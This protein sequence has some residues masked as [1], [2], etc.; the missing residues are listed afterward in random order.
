MILENVTTKIPHK[1]VIDKLDL[2]LEVDMM[3]M[4]QTDKLDLADPESLIHWF[5]SV[6]D[7]TVFKYG[8]GGWGGQD[9]RIESKL[10][11][12]LRVVEYNAA[13]DSEREFEIIIKTTLDNTKLR[14][15]KTW[16]MQFKVLA[17]DDN[18]NYTLFQ[19][20]VEWTRLPN[21]SLNREG[22]VEG[23]KRRNLFNIIKT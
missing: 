22:F 19:H 3:H 17:L 1:I 13:G 18:Y 16:V 2:D 20:Q 9:L 5:Y 8:F 14:N 10:P 12:R 7:N 11:H 6:C 23:L 4:L 21:E 15:P